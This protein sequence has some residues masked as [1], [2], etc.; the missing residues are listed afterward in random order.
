MLFVHDGATTQAGELAVPQGMLY[1]IEVVMKDY[2][3]SGEKEGLMWDSVALVS[4][5]DEPF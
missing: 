5:S 4:G 3:E 2:D 1:D